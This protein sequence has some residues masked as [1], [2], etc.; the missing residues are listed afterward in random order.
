MT[1]TV[2]TSIQLAGMSIGQLRKTAHGLKVNTGHGLKRMSRQQVIDGIMDKVSIAQDPPR[3][4]PAPL[5]ETMHSEGPAG[6]IPPV[7][8]NRLQFALHSTPAIRGACLFGP[9]G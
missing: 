1:D 7:W 4:N 2:Y 9:R 8:F 6:F 3:D 5:I